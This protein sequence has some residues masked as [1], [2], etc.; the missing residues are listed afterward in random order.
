MKL[1]KPLRR[2]LPRRRRRLRPVE[3]IPA[4]EV[5]GALLETL[6]GDLQ[7][8]LGVQWCVGDALPLRE[9]WRETESG[10][11]RSIHLMHALMDRTAQRDAKRARRWRVAIA[12]AGLCAQG[13]GRIY[14]EAAME[15]CCAVVGLAPLRAGSGAD[16]EVLRDRLLTEAVHELGHLAGLAHCRNASCVMY[17]SLHIADTDHK[18]RTFCRECRRPLKLRELQEP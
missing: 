4:G 14:G 8:A 16:A 9:E 7:N 13:V 17:P 10:L 3:L 5:D 1:A 6:G 11:Y 15:G 2:V 18:G 12:D